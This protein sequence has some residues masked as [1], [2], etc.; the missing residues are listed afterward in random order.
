M[1]TKR[2]PKEVEE[3]A[4]KLGL[5]SRLVH[6]PRSI[7]QADGLLSIQNALIQYDSKA[8]AELSQHTSH[9]NDP[10]RDLTFT[11]DKIQAIEDYLLKYY[12]WLL[13]YSEI[14]TL[15]KL[16]DKIQDLSHITTDMFV[17]QIMKSV[18]SELTELK[19]SENMVIKGT[20]KTPALKSV[21]KSILTEN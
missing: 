15:H 13:F 2:Q 19:F 3:Y 21:F 4:K 10:G 7:M 6:I 17:E 11:L 5:D 20:G 16:A 14:Q 12:D 8:Y 18:V 9:I 1:G